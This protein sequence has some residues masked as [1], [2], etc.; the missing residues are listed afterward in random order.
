M[1]FRLFQ[2]PLPA[3]TEL[4]ELNS[5]L[6]SQR[7]ATVTH[8]LVQTP[9]GGMLVFVVECVGGPASKAV[10][11]AGPKVDY[12]EQLDAVEFAT[13]NRLRDQ[14]KRWADEEGLPVY[15]VFTNAQLA[16][17]AKGSFTTVAD[18]AKI[19]GLGPARVEKYGARL[20]ALLA[21]PPASEAPP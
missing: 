10:P 19:E 1:R 15:T 12:R 3:P 2:Y 8:H 11:S 7:I 4:D 16:A 21:T 5:F 9:G 6:A 14:R 18:L 13:F 20:L 17:L